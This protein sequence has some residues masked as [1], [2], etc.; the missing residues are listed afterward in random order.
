MQVISL[1]K[2]RTNQT[3]V[4][5]SALKG[6]SILLTSR[7]GAFRLTPVSAEEKIVARIGE[8]LEEAK[9]IENGE[10]EAKNAKVFL[11]EL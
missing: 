2:F 8:G 1:T 7:L 10:L 9:R 3:A 6:E 11:D 5:L 4:L